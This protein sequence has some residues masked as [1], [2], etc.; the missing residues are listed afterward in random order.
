[1]SPHCGG[2]GVPGRRGGR[3][4]PL[5][6]V[7]VVILNRPVAGCTIPPG[8][9]NDG[10]C[11]C[12]DGSD[13]PLTAA[14]AG[15]ACQPFPCL[16]AVPPLSS[17]EIPTGHVGDGICDCCDG[18]DEPL[19]VC[20]DRC[21]LQRRSVQHDAGHRQT[22]LTQ[23][24]RVRKAIVKDGQPCIGRITQDL[25]GIKDQIKVGRVRLQHA[26][27]DGDQAGAADIYQELVNLHSL[28]N[29]REALLQ[30]PAQAFGP[31]FEHC[32]LREMCYSLVMTEKAFR[33]GSVDPA[34]GVFN[35]TVCPFRYV[36]QSL[37]SEDANATAPVVLGMWVGWER[38]RTPHEI[39]EDRQRQRLLEANRTQNLER[40][41][42]AEEAAAAALA[43]RTNASAIVEAD[44]GDAD[45]SPL[46]ATEG[47]PGLAGVAQADS[48]TPEPPI[49]REEMLL[50]RFDFRQGTVE[51]SQTLLFAG[52]DPCWGG[53]ERTFRLTLICGDR[54]LV[55]LR[56][57]GKCTYHADL[58]HPIRCTRAMLAQ[59]MAD[60][61]G[62]EEDEDF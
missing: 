29:D 17:M 43:N 22:N 42:L 38:P 25:K 46:T 57:D 10:Y 59:A 18:S 54:G 14:C 60:S 37:V 6:V 27:E 45:V 23:W 4:W 30:Y 44:R 56:E 11:D 40:E 12:S 41:R 26:Q 9:T 52:G 31:R 20:P 33:G 58:E 53:P 32:P 49:S 5:W 15:V 50:R 62:A 34:P 28:K 21:D 2:G 1:M 48:P 47:E 24:L 13:E 36:I 61:S 8:W 55:N 7:I 3:H 51:E 39:V 35:F 16:R 19:N